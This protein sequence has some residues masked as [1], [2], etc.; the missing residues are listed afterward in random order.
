MLSDSTLPYCG[1]GFLTSGSNTYTAYYCNTYQADAVW[2]IQATATIADYPSSTPPS[3][4]QSI[5]STSRSITSSSS[6]TSS[7]S[8]LTSP[9]ANTYVIS[10]TL[11]TGPS[12]GST[13]TAAG[14]SSTGTASPTPKKSTNV[15]AIAGGVVGGVV[16]LAAI[17][18]GIAYMLHRKK[19]N[20]RRQS[21]LEIS[22]VQ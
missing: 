7:S 20:E 11:T 8:T 18:G 14:Q 22:Q 4:S 19:A 2:T 9:T 13:G 5:S 17:I 21:R 15:G 6:Q 12:K 1:T 3:S 16:G 10:S